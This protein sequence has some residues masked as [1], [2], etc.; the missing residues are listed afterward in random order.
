MAQRSFAAIERPSDVISLLIQGDAD[1]AAVTTELA[2]A[3]T[4]C[5]R[6]PGH[7]TSVT[8]FPIAEILL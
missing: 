2:A 3:L 7:I 6:S 4:R 8:R 1:D 5:L